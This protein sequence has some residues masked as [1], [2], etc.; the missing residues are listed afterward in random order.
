VIRYLLDTNVVVAALRPRRRD[1]YLDDRLAATDQQT[2]ISTITLAE[3][4]FGVER[5]SDHARNLLAVEEFV[6]YVEVRDFDRQS[7]EH[8]GQI[9]AELA[10]Q[11]T[12]IGPHDTLI[13]AYAR[14]H[15]LILV[16]NNTREFCRVAGLRVED[17]TQPD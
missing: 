16:T 4:I 9:R 2:A 5:S 15:G 10:R 12:P 13:A 14:A 11:G 3:L 6:S 8:A 17:W 7:A 1:H